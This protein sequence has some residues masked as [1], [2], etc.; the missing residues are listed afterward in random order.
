MFKIFDY[1]HVSARIT[2]RM[3]EE[4]VWKPP[5]LGQRYLGKTLSILK[6]IWRLKATNMLL[7]H[8]KKSKLIH[9]ILGVKQKGKHTHKYRYT[10]NWFRAL[11]SLWTRI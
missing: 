6:P 10:R 2:Q 9:C 4:F 3:W 5:P 1:L 11:G 8:V 7:L